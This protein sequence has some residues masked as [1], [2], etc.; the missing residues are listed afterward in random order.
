[1]GRKVVPLSP[2]TEHRTIV[3]VD[4]AEFTRPDRTVPHQLAVQEGLHDVL[5]AALAAA[6]ADPAGCAIEDRGDGALILVPS[7]VPKSELAEKLPD[8]LVAEI[9]RHNATRDRGAQFKLRVGLH[10]GDIRRNEHGW[11]GNAVNLACRILESEEA[12]AELGRSEQLVALIASSHFYEEVIAQEPASA[13]ESYRRINVVVKSFEGHA[14][15]RLHGETG[16]PSASLQAARPSEEDRLVR[17]L[18]NEDELKVLQGLLSDVETTRL[19]MLVSRAT[20][21]A[22]PVR[23]FGSVWDAFDYLADV[24]AGPDGIPPAIEF[25]ELLAAD[26]GDENGSELTAWVAQKIH[27]LRR[28]TEQQERQEGRFP[29]P[30]EPRLHLM[31]VIELDAIDDSR[32]VL[33]WWRQDD[34]LE[35]PPLRGGVCELAADELEQ[36]IDD[37]IIE[38]EGVWSDQAVS[39]ALE[40]VMPRSLLQL[41]IM[42]WRKEHRSGDPRPLVYDYPLVLRSLERMRSAH[43]HRLWRRR[44]DSALDDH[45]PSPR[46]IHPYGLAETKENP[47]DAVLSESTWVGLVMDEPPSAHPDPS[48]GPDA[49]TAALRAGLPLILWHPSAS[50]EDLRELVSRLVTADGGLSGLPGRHRAA[51]LAATEDDLIRNLVVLLD[52]PDRKIVPGGP[53]SP[54]SSGGRK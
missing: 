25:L 7:S 18:L 43:W 49:L 34:P 40:F 45:P 3:V 9:R 54:T 44:W 6:G 12:K 46:R 23:R 39:V 13:P 16:P 53:L 33:S 15:L 36:R 30:A 20:R 42:G 10:A 24:N 31:I 4:V 2:P 38:A 28:A 52:D 32:C 21:A 50:A 17:S 51:R 1:M 26:L 27:T 11:V 35:W 41:P 22:I 37:V 8:R 19:P 29:V 47:I 5:R 14:W 48:A